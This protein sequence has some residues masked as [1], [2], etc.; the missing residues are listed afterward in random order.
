MDYLASDGQN[1]DEVI[2]AGNKL[3]YT[4]LRTMDKIYQDELSEEER[5][6]ADELSI[7]MPIKFQYIIPAYKR[8][9][10]AF[11]PAKDK[12]EQAKSAKKVLRKTINKFKCK[13]K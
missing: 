9:Y 10:K 3:I 13:K 12:S 7:K 8:E 6:Q 1:S 4:Y 5:R 11:G 2:R